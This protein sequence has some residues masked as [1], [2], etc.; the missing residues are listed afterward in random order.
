MKLIIVLISALS[1][2]GVSFTAI[3]DGEIYPDAKETAT[4]KNQP[5]VI[6]FGVKQK[7]ICVASVMTIM[8]Y[9]HE[10]I[11]GRQANPISSVVT[12]LRIDDNSKWNWLCK[13]NN[14]QVIYAAMNID[15]P[16]KIKIGRWRTHSLDEKIS[17]KV[18]NDNLTISIKYTGS[19]DRVK[20]FPLKEVQA[21][22]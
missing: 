6:I 14:D 18:D 1:L 2:F 7:N 15:G 5:D 10:N 13:I 21:W 3:A 20:S 22:R 12:R 11:R 9:E 16:D 8:G 17:F 19:S 4:I